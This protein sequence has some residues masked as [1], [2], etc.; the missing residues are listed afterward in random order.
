MRITLF[1]V[2]VYDG[3][4]ISIIVMMCTHT[5]YSC[6]DNGMHTAELEQQSI[7]GCSI[8]IRGCISNGHRPTHQSAPIFTIGSVTY[9][10]MRGG[11]GVLEQVGYFGHDVSTL[12]F[13]CMVLAASVG[14]ENAGTHTWLPQMLQT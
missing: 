8:N 12:E 4:V 6:A 1:Y 13:Y 10:R 3:N 7:A 5:M 11:P 14:V 9:P 2:C